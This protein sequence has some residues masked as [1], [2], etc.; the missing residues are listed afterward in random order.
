MDGLSRRMRR[1][2][3]GHGGWIEALLA[4][5][6]MA[7]LGVIVAVSALPMSSSTARKVGLTVQGQA[8]RRKPPSVLMTWPVTQAASSVASQAIRR[9]GSSGDPQRPCGK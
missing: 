8:Q 7:A 4:A 6:A 9:A 5:S 3:S 1:I 2:S